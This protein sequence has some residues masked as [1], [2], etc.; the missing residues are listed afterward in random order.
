MRRKVVSRE[1][2]GGIARSSRRDGKRIV[3]TNGCF[4]L[5]HLGHVRYLRAAREQGDLLVVGL[6]SDESV[7][8][9]K[10]PGRPLVPEGDR[11]ELLAAL[12]MV[13]YIVL[14]PED[15]PAELIAEVK[16][17]VLVKGGDYRP[18]E[19]AGQDTVKASGGRV[20]II[21]LVESRSTTSL[22]EKIRRQERGHLT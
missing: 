2:I 22:I 13:D 17:D 5:L 10:G 16:P 1:E 19:I 9:L 6:N 20:V 8:R 7:R 3:F 4:D 21:P 12:E 18:E 14:F 11:A 15:T